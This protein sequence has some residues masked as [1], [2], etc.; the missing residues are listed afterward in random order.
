MAFRPVIGITLDIE[1]GY[2]RLRDE[3]VKA[4]V[5]AGGIPLLVPPQDSPSLVNILDGLIIPGGDDP[6]PSYFNEE[7]HPL[8]RIAPR[9]RSDFELSLIGSLIKKNKPIL[10]ICYGMQLINI[11][12]GGSL[13]QDI[14]S[15]VRDTID[16]KDDHPVLIKDN[17]FFNSEGF[18]INS[19]HH[20]A[21]KDIGKR[22]EIL[23]I[24]SDGI[25]EGFYLKGY[26]FLLGLQWHPERPLKR[27]DSP[28]SERY[29]TLSENIFKLMIDRS[30][31]RH[32]IK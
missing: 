21:V 2:Y 32:G 5:K 13:Y 22:L 29:D 23:A 20:Q 18:M 10:G 9:K 24:A 26:I 28:E 16:H 25:I 17:P 7:P 14:K 27:H 15:Q 3:Y 8:T 1:K 11:F 30:K 4:V 31:E 6:D 19:S 12:F